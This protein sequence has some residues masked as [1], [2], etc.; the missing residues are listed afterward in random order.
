MAVKKHGY[1]SHR[2]L[3]VAKYQ[4]AAPK[5]LH[6]AHSWQD[7]FPKLES[8]F[9][10]CCVFYPS[11][12]QAAWVQSPFLRVAQSTW[13]T[14]SKDVILKTIW[15][16]SGRFCPP[17]SLTPYWT[18]NFVGCDFLVHCVRLFFSMVISNS[19][20]RRLLI[21]SFFHFFFLVG[22]FRSNFW[23]SHDVSTEKSEKQLVFKWAKNLLK[24]LRSDKYFAFE[25]YK[26]LTFSNYVE[27]FLDSSNKMQSRTCNS[28]I[29]TSLTGST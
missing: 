8:L 29:S 20:R 18:T 3:T 16:Y 17:S 27:F 25:E 6:G 2:T 11:S 13:A 10:T 19:P 9:S 4:T 23:K 14:F 28:T 24:Q 5:S 22:L 7:R 12:P 26:R 21:Q 15:S 1:Y